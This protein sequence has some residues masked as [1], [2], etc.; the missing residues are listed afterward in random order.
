MLACG[1]STVPIRRVLLLNSYH[2]GYTWTDDIVRGAQDVLL[3][4]GVPIDLAIEYLDQRRHEDPVTADME[5]PKSANAFEGLLQNKF[6]NTHFDVIITSDDAALKFLLARRDHLFPGVP[7]VFCGVNEYRGTSAYVTAHPELRPWLTGVLERIDVDATVDL[8]LRLHPGTRFVVTVGE[9]N[10]PRYR[11]D[12]EIAKRHPGLQVRRIPAQEISL[13][14][15]GRQ[16]NALKPD[17]IV[18]LSA[19]P[20]DGAGH[21]FSLKDSVRFVCQHSRAP[22][23]GVNKDALGLGIV[24]GKL[25]D[26]IAQ[27]RAAGSLAMSVLRGTPPS[28][29]GIRWESP[30]PYE[31]DWRQ[32]HRWHVPV[33]LLP[34]GSIV[35]NRP[36][37]L[38]ALHP[39]WFW[40]GFVFALL[41]SFA[42]A[43]LLI[44][45]R[46][47][48]RAESELAAHAQQ[49]ARS[50][51]MLEQV[52]YVTAHDFQEPMR[53]VAICSELLARRW[54]ATLDKDSE[55][56]LEFVL[57]GA[58]K[59]HRMVRGL[60]DWVRAV[61]DSAEVEATVDSAA[62]F[63]K[64]VESR[65]SEIERTGTA[66]AVGDLPV[67]RMQEQHLLSIWTHLLD[68]ALTFH[69]KEAPRITVD[70]ERV[71]GAWKFSMQ[72]N[73]IGIPAA[74]RGR[75]FDVFKRLNS[76]RESGIGM[77][78]AICRRVVDF[79]SGRIWVDSKDGHGATFYF[80]IPDY[81]KSATRHRRLIAFQRKG[82]GGSDPH[83]RGQP[84]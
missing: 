41:Q 62:T 79:Y 19:F 8:A 40:G 72:D 49:L 39:V 83:R 59:M 9:G 24:G 42:I 34:Q 54:H 71:Q 2:Q 58:K 21:L 16:L 74:F 68:N 63:K 43:L 12:L 45:Q 78:L 26:G 60:L 6:D 75:I 29:L 35:I 82:K 70:A 22:V 80:T 20:R 66:I 17:T 67:L 23:Y 51:Y 61:E 76:T 32:L 46:R 73:G 1:A 38:Y 36:K 47:M 69:N 15:T 3:Q 27:G 48:R 4:S 5:D 84:G 53:N 7:V 11:Y 33:S 13:D 50:N 81:K 52:A 57:T 25:N 55:E 44:Q 56:L 64:V 10:S 77:G 28:R 37:S 31:F 65:H 30:N 14:E 18:L